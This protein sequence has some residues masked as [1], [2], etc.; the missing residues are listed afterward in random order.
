MLSAE[1]AQLLFK[2]PGASHDQSKWAVCLRLQ[3]SYGIEQITRSFAPRKLRRVK[4]RGP[5]RRQIVSL[6]NIRLLI[7]RKV[8]RLHETI[9]VHRIRYKENLVVGYTHRSIEVRIC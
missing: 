1:G 4:H 9:V 8:C 7:E 6:P 3:M 5:V 2:L